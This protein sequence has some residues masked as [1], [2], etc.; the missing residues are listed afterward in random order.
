M[1]E[2]ARSDSD[3]KKTIATQNIKDAK[4]DFVEDLEENEAVEDDDID[5]MRE[6]EVDGKG[7]YLSTSPNLNL[8]FAND[9]RMKKVIPSE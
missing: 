9:H 6:L 4:Y 3:V 7:T 5:W 8:I 2:T 1:G